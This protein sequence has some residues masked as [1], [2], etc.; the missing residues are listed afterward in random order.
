[1]LQIINIDTINYHIN[2][3]LLEI[4]KRISAVIK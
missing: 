1:M 3:F 4:E 2:F